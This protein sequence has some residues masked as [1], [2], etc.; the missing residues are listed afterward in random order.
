LGN[1]NLRAAVHAA[2][3]GRVGKAGSDNHVRCVKRCRGRYARDGEGGSGI[4][5][6][7]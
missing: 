4:P 3:E 1:R 5:K 7:W 6:V 2:D